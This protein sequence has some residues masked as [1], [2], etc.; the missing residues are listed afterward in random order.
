MTQLHCIIS[1]RVQRV[2]FRDF[3]Q[4]K[5]RGLGIVG[6]VRNLPD[7]TVE[8]SAQGERALLERYLAKLHRGPWL[9]RVES[10]DSQWGND[11]EPLSGFEIR[12]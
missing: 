4:R 12:Y 11:P 3:A 5:A 9:A 7:G 1:G 2:M 10:V 6:W 8:V